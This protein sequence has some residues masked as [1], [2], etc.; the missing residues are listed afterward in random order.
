MIEANRHFT[1]SELVQGQLYEVILPFVDFDGAVHPTGERWRYL[2]KTFLPYED[3]LTLLIERDG[4]NTSI[5]LRWSEDAQ[6]EIVDHFSEYV[7]RLPETG[8]LLPVQR[9][10][11]F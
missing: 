10:G 5:R 2:A 9:T 8:T 3:G 1:A 4:V 6:G 7:T 11:L